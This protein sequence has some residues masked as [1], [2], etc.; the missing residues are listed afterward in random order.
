MGDGSEDLEPAGRLPR[1]TGVEAPP[2]D[3]EADPDVG[4]ALVYARACGPL[5]GLLT[6]MGG[7]ATDAEEV[8]QDAFVKLLEHWPKVRGYDDVDAWLRTV[9]ARM[10]I[11]RHRRRQVA[12]LGLRRIAART[13]LAAPGS[14]SGARLDVADALA[15]LP[16]GY[17]AVVLLHHV[18]D[19][20]VADVADLLRLPVGT[21]KSRLARARAALA[22]LLTDPERT[23]T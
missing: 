17:R 22:P 10:L 5:I 4:V 14:D 15:T 8:A 18:H 3:P 20:P 1:V 13:E 6:V 21:V 2:E 7:S 23:P 11:S 19:L 12:T 9:A 16:V